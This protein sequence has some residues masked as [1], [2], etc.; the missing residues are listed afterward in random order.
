MSAKTEA[1]KLKI[2]KLVDAI[3]PPPEAREAILAVATHAYVMGLSDTV[4][5]C[6]A[7]IELAAK[8]AR[9]LAEPFGIQFAQTPVQNTSEGVLSPESSLQGLS[10]RRPYR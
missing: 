10:D 4:V 2:E 6:H 3:N 1:A 7:A 9:E 5:D 8:T